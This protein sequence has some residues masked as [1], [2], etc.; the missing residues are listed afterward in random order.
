MRF[1]R[2][3]LALDPEVSPLGAKGLCELTAV[4]VAPAI[5]NPSMTRPTGECAT[6]LITTEKLL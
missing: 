2:I 6:L 4:S 3:A 1:L 5:A